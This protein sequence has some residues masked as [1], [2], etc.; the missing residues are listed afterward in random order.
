MIE[1]RPEVLVLRLEGSKGEC[2]ILS[3]RVGQPIKKLIALSARRE[4]CNYQVGNQAVGEAVMTDWR[5]AV[6]IFG[7]K[8]WAGSSILPGSRAGLAKSEGERGEVSPSERLL[9]DPIP[10]N[11]FL[12]TSSSRCPIM[13]KWGLTAAEITA[14]VAWRSKHGHPSYRGH[15]HGHMPA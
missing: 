11:R 13:S 4:H 14:V 2:G 5:T 15:R 3:K 8:A 12:T 1:S 9:P 6:G 7:Q 10:L